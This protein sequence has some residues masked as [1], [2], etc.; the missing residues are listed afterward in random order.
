[1]KK[2][3][4]ERNEQLIQYLNEERH[5]IEQASG[6]RTDP[7]LRDTHQ[8]ITERISKLKME[9]FREQYEIFENNLNGVPGISN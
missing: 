7:D 2:K 1:M 9:V 6:F 8:F 4:K 5:K 3:I